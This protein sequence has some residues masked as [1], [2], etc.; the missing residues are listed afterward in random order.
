MR[1][2]FLLLLIVTGQASVSHGQCRL[3]YSNYVPVFIETF[4]D[5]D[6]VNQLSK[7]WKTWY[8]NDSATGQ[9]YSWGPEVWSNKNLTFMH[10]NGQS[11]VRLLAKRLA[12]PVHCD[13]CPEAANFKGDK[14]YVSGMLELVAGED[15]TPGY[16]YGI[17]EAKLRFSNSSGSWPAFWM[18]GVYAGPPSTTEIDIVDGYFNGDRVWKSNLIDWSYPGAASYQV[19]NKW[20]NNDLTEN[21][22]LFSLVW[23]PQKLAYF[24]DGRELF[25]LSNPVDSKEKPSKKVYTKPEKLITLLTMQMADWSNADSAYMDVDYVKVYK[26]CS[27]ENGGCKPLPQL[28][29]Y[30]YNTTPYIKCGP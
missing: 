6:S 24:I 27:R 7:S 13:N 9:Y 21:F 16:T 17:F 8:P 4:D 23:T 15:S 5:I 30:D 25:T 20:R 3:D 12:K 10:E 2:I 11:Y 19:A 26:P 18:V 22:H 1:R 29:P 28:T 14:K